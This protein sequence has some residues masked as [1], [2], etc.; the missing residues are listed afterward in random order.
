ML[1]KAGPCRHLALEQVLWVLSAIALL[2]F[3]ARS[4]FVVV[5]GGCLVHFGMFTSILGLHALDARSPLA[6]TMKTIPRY[7]HMFSGDKLSAV[8]NH[9]TSES[10]QPEQQRG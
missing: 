10:S 3:Q 4:F 1:E 8:G 7:C 6:V 2:T 5:G 9:C